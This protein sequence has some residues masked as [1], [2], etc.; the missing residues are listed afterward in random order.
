[1]A[2]AAGDFGWGGR[3]LR[4]VGFGLW[5]VVRQEE[6]GGASGGGVAARGDQRGGGW[7]RPWGPGSALWGGARGSGDRGLARRCSDGEGGA[8]GSEGWR[9]AAQGDQTVAGGG[10]KGP[11]GWRRARLVW[12]LTGGRARGRGTRRV[13]AEVADTLS[14]KS[15]HGD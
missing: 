1:V 8:W 5:P 14:V 13:S 10:T 7:R 2:A 12:G 6:G 11:V 9:V 4:R 3:E 15:A